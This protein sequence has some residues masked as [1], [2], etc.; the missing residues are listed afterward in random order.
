MENL[1][2]LGFFF[3]H[4]EILNKKE[5][6]SH[7]VDFIGLLRLLQALFLIAAVH[8]DWDSARDK[9]AGVS[10]SWR[11]NTFSSTAWKTNTSFPVSTRR[12]KNPLR[13][14]LLPPKADCIFPRSFNV[15]RISSCKLKYV[16]FLVGWKKIIFRN[17][18]EKKRFH[19]FS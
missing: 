14:M 13:A 7:F 2:V 17:Y 12:I 9:M 5:V 4:H 6:I 18:Q 3:I 1:S 15:T 10:C 11:C 8:L 16:T 19:V